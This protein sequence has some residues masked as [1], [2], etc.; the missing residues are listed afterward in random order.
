MTNLIFIHGVNSQPTGYSNRLYK[1]ILTFYQQGL[2]KQGAT[3][4]AASKASRQLVQKEI[5]W[6]HHTS[7]WTNR[8][9]TLQYPLQPRTGKWNFIL[10]AVDPLVIQILHYVKDK[11][12]KKGPMDMLKHIHESF[13][14]ACA[15]RPDNIVVIA[16]SLGS[17][18]AFD[19][20]FGFRKY[21]YTG[22]H[23]VV[24]FFTLGSPIPLFTSAM[25]Y[26]ENPVKRPAYLKK[27]INILDPDDGVARHCAT[28]FRRVSIE[29]VE[30]NTGWDPLGAHVRYWHTPRVA[31]CIASQL[32]LKIKSRP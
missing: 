28:H 25:G 11:G 31:E 22:H 15:N 2:L 13:R 30:I 14:E 9:L 1:N 16:H 5:L 21:K 20:L 27:W 32:L 18:I 6:A 23:P 4:Q 24:A 3:R 29:D 19:Y 7:N 8:F 12:H 26:V 10:K 17:V